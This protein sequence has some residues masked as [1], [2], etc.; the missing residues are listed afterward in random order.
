MSFEDKAVEFRTAAK[1]LVEGAHNL[2]PGSVL[3]DDKAASAMAEH[4][5]D[6]HQAAEMLEFA[7]LICEVVGL[8]KIIGPLAARP[9]DVDYES[10]GN[11]DSCITDV[12][13]NVVFDL[14]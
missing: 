11:F 4:V 8:A 12:P 13:W 14:G 7:A 3:Y 1:T 5:M 10:E 2:D 6:C 9:T